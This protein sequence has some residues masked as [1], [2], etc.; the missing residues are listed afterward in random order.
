MAEGMPLAFAA[1]G[2]P[3]HLAGLAPA[4]LA[5]PRADPARPAGGGKVGLSL[6]T[7]LAA[8]ASGAGQVARRRRASRRLCA[9]KA[10]VPDSLGG[11]STECVTPGASGRWF[12]PCCRQILLVPPSSGAAGE[13]VCEPCG[14]GLGAD[15]KKPVSAA[16]DFYRFVNHG[17]LADESIKIPE[18]YPSWGSFIKLVDDSVKNQIKLAK[19]LVDGAS[20]ADEKKLALVWNACMKC[21]EDWEK[22]SGD[23]AGILD[24]L[25]VLDKHLQ[26]DG[27]GGFALGLASYMSRCQ[28]VGI[29]CPF[30]FG[31]EA[32]LKDTENMVLDL[33]PSGTSLP[34]RDYYFDSKFAEQREF[35]KAHLESVL[36]LI[37]AE[38]LV[39]DFA[40]RVMRFE[41]K[42]AQIKM[43]QDQE[44]LYDQ[45]F[46]VTTLDEM[47]EAPNAMVYLEAKNANYTENEVEDADP[48]KGV[49]TSETWTASA[50]DTELMA[51]F[52]KRV[53]HDMQLREVMS[54][55]FSK[56]YPERDDAEEA[57]YRMMLFDG[58]YF[59]RL[60][61]ILLRESNQK[62]VKAYMQYQIIKSMQSFCTKALDDECFDF[63][64]RKL[65][66]QKEQKSVDKRTIQRVNLWLGELMGKVYA[67]K[68]FPDDDKKVVHGMVEDVLNIM[69]KSLKRN[70]WLTA[71]TKEKA[72]LK[73]SRFV[74][75][76]G[77]PDKLKSYDSLDLVE[78]DSLLTLRKKVLAFNFR[79]EF[80][81]KVNSVKDKT[82]WEMNPQDVNAYFHPLNNEIV[83]PAAIM[84]PPFYH[85]SL[86]Q[87]DLNLSDMPKAN[88]PTLLEAINYGGIG[89]VIAHEITHGFDDQ[90]RKFDSDGN[91]N[92]W[93][94]EADADL[95][96]SKCGLMAEQA[97][98]WE[99]TDENGNAVAGHSMNSALTMGENLADLGGMSLACQA[100]QARLGEQCR[101]EH[102]V[103]FYRNWA[104]LWR[105]KESRAYSIQKLSVDPHAPASFRGNLV[106]N[107]DS[108]YEAFDI[109]EGDA[110][111]VAP[112]K[113]VQMW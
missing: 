89:A 50:A 48:D 70:D 81:E 32:N 42:L 77:S 44:R 40:A 93:W 29:T 54:A 111:Y 18:E 13:M 41:T 74:A 64:G 108:F 100:L 57:Q 103:A 97:A 67:A 52:W 101:P 102:L 55:N 21:F 17:W 2:P 7:A 37:G 56:N 94:T 82:K 76:L 113:R 26:G 107:V 27:D 8:A 36:G 110:M 53:V 66:G 31:K 23:H 104:N 95:F 68:Y 63:Y 1:A 46:N 4:T 58:D 99:F 83:F 15:E 60:F 49:L 80:L 96:E 25:E 92:D 30:S 43:K 75:K 69:E 59:R 88:D 109:R 73:L 16:D 86:E 79:T 24:E 51:T 20:T 3:R 12:C 98:R 14:A 72:L 78:S 87:T 61:P 22:G 10:L 5:A 9:L 19:E 28:E 106:S 45:F 35:F 6:T 112:E 11:S 47:M 71:E 65:G 105:S 85:Q 34:G 84:Q 91:I 62:D 33:S 39:D 38:N 90:G